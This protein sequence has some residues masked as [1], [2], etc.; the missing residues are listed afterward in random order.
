MTSHKIVQFLGRMI[1]AI[2]GVKFP[3]GEKSVGQDI[4]GASIPWGEKSVGRN[5]Y[6]L[7][8]IQKRS[9]LQF[10]HKLPNQNSFGL[11]IGFGRSL[12]SRTSWDASFQEKGCVQN[13]LN[14]YIR[15]TAVPSYFTMVDGIN[16]EKIL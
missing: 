11:G 2:I 14:Y 3:R 1:L 16:P 12:I 8:N 7:Q 9:N 15:T 5:I 4:R 13:D 10:Q 6:H